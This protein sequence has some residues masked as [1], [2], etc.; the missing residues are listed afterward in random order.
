MKLY[1]FATPKAENIAT[2]PAPSAQTILI[3]DNIIHV[4]GLSLDETSKAM[5][6]GETF[7][8]TP[9]ITPGDATNKAVEWSTSDGDV[10]TVS[11]GVVTAHGVGTATIT[12]MS[13][14]DNTVTATCTVTVSKIAVTGV[15]LNRSKL[16]LSLDKNT[17]FTLVPTIAP[18]DAS[19]KEVEW[20]VSPSGVVTVVDGVVTAQAAGSATVT[21]ASTDNPSA[22]A[23]CEVTVRAASEP[24]IYAYGLSAGNDDASHNV[25]ITYSL[26]AAAEAVTIEVLKGETALI[27]EPL[28]DPDDMTKGDHTYTLNVS[29]L[30][31]G[32]YTW[33]VTAE[34]VAPTETELLTGNVE[35]FRLYSPRGVA[36]NVFPE[37]EDFGNV[38][39]TMPLNGASDGASETTK[40]QKRGIFMWDAAYTLKAGG[41][42][43]N[44]CGLTFGTTTGSLSTPFRIQVAEDGNVFVSGAIS[45]NS[46]VWM[47]DGKLANN[48]QPVLS[49]AGIVYGFAVTG[50]A[51]NL[52]VYTME[53]IAYQSTGSIKK[54][55]GITAI[56]Y[57]DA[58]IEVMDI[59]NM[60]AQKLTSLA[61][62]GRGG[63]WV[64]QYRG[65]DGAAL[66]IVAHISSAGVKDWTS[67][68]GGLNISYN[69]RGA[70]AVNAD[71]TKLAVVS[72]R[73]GGSL[74]DIYV[75]SIAWNEGVPVLT[76]IATATNVGKNL[77]GIAFD[78]AD[79][80]Y[81][82]SSSTELLKV[83]ATPKAENK[84]T[85]PAPAAQKIT[86]ANSVVTGI[87]N[88]T[89]N[90]KYMH[91]VW[92][93]T[94]QY[95]G[96]S[97]D[98]LQKGI[99]I[100]NGKKVVK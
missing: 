70:M 54:Y 2:T 68:G 80:L 43:A 35:E 44:E 10:A 53:D 21:V 86:I 7:T 30:P 92:T 71:K 38:Y 5:L 60:I 65:D 84:A 3:T 4:T 27:T 52:N 49:S 22:T 99:Y 6:V 45:G 29:T 81:A 36:V 37:T 56:P 23:T 89:D 82:V 20:S 61:T 66:P 73:S 100:I 59:K 1:I 75:Y 32:E 57:A 9:T 40:T 25:E 87:E 28:S 64:T 33:R 77:D 63:Y 48:F 85:T 88:T 98:N 13:N 91:G 8:L 67:Y 17:S 78:Y 96:E 24:N 31:N 18:D 94:G 26:N 51:G 58:G 14:D 39:V 55:E 12:A 41:A 83:W 11:N 72:L 90:A 15:T 34:A 50:T 74:Y 69:Y 97:A 46:G 76:K 93:I 16:S 95:L 19:F 79:N 47:A 42:T 62:D